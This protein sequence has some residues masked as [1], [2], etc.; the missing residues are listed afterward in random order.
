M[1][2]TPIQSRQS[3]SGRR[4]AGVAALTVLRGQDPTAA[5]GKDR[6]RSRTTRP[7]HPSNRHTLMA[8]TRVE[9]SPC[10]NRT[11]PNASL[12]GTGQYPTGRKT[13]T[14][15]RREGGAD[16]KTLSRNA[17]G[18]WKVVGKICR[19]AR[20]R[21]PKLAESNIVSV[22]VVAS[23]AAAVSIMN[24]SD[25]VIIHARAARI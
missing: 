1:F 22:H 10:T 7:T 11:R 4:N 13:P 21:K 16:I 2:F 25:R 5:A 14:A 24:V 15:Q 12:P 9:P 8:K 6:Q 19:C 18:T 3:N 23:A 20:K 17:R